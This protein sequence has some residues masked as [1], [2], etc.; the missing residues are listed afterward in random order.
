MTGELIYPQTEGQ[1]TEDPARV[2]ARKELDSA[3]EKRAAEE[4]A[5][6]RRTRRKRC[7]SCGE[8]FER[9]KLNP[10]GLCIKCQKEVPTP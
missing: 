1:Q 2:R 5:K 3:R 10:K 8:L 9:G 6:T 4:R 7:E